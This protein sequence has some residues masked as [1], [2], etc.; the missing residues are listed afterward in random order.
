M[1][2]DRVQSNIIQPP[3]NTPGWEPEAG[4]LD[5]NSEGLRSEEGP[6]GHYRLSQGVKLL[7]S[8]AGLR[9][10]SLSREDLAPE[11]PDERAHVKLAPDKDTRPS[12]PEAVLGLEGEGRR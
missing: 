10:S 6:P 4:P 1:A 9:G 11:K 2:A 8:R 3:P 7:G 12:A 5:W